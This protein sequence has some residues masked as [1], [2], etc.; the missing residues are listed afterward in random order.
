LIESIITDT[1]N[2]GKWITKWLVSVVA[3]AYGNYSPLVLVLSGERQGT[4]KTHFFRY[5]LPK[6]LRYLFGESKMD[7]GKDDEILMTKKTYHSR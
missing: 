3:S 7:N 4:G 1:K 2:H 6:K 5:L